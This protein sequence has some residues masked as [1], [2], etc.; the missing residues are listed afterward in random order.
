MHLFGLVCN[1]RNRGCTVSSHC[2]S[3]E[4]VGN[5]S[6]KVWES[7]GKSGKVWESLGKSG[8]ALSRIVHRLFISLLP[9]NLCS[10]TFTLYHCLQAFFWTLS[11]A[12]TN[13]GYTDIFRW[14]LISQCSTSARRLQVSS[15][16]NSLGSYVLSR[17]ATYLCQTAQDPPHEPSVASN[18]WQQFHKGGGLS[19][20]H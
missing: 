16:R 8:E 4:Y 1:L 12:A 19:V 6:G 11:L 17:M 20:Q 3:G 14:A 10:A 5:M 18:E 15:T 9:W 7:L 13:V 2:Q